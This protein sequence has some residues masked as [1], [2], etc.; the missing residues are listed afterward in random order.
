MWGCVMCGR[1]RESALNIDVWTVEEEI[2]IIILYL[3][4]GISEGAGRWPE[5]MSAVGWVGSSRE[6]G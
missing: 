5:F 1:R 3:S 2:I 6:R 4:I